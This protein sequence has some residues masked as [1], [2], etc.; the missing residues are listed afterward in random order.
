MKKIAF[1]AFD[2][3][4]ATSN[5]F[6]CQLGLVVVRE[7]RIVEEKVFLI[8]PP[9]NKYSQSCIAVHGITP[10]ATRDS[11]EFNQL[12]SEIKPYFD[13]ELMIAHNADFDI[14]VLRK[15]CDYYNLEKPRPLCFHCTMEIYNGRSLKDISYALGI[16]I[17]NHHDALADARFCANI[18][19]KYLEGINPED[20]NYPTK[21]ESNRKERRNF[22]FNTDLK[23]RHISSETKVQDLS[24]VK[25]RDTIF[26]AKK[27]VIS[28][29]FDRFPLRDDLG[30]LLKSYGADM[31]GGISKQTNLFIIGTNAGPKK[32]ETVE[33]LQSEGCLI[34]VIEEAQLYEI[35]NSIK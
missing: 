35:L 25:N 3:E 13:H 8:K 33:K 15:A 16:E 6:P 23:N 11:L 20:L 27:V 9:E 30:K 1:T 10:N 19:V 32:M 22:A 34:S 24:I 28:G 2:F 5:R 18:F 17:G 4:T 26:Y 7:G 14:D 12:W 31:K 21:K 29:V